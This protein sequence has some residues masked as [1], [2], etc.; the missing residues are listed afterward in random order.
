MRVP[1]KKKDKYET[2]KKTAC[3]FYATM[4]ADTAASKCFEKTYI[5]T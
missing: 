2:G 1:G 3:P 4:T 5:H